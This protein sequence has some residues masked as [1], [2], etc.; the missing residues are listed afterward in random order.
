MEVPAELG[1]N[2]T[3]IFEEFSLKRGVHEKI[4]IGNTL[5]LISRDPTLVTRGL[6]WSLSEETI[7]FLSWKDLSY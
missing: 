6:G 5:D 2:R 3:L 4:R 1:C 7:G